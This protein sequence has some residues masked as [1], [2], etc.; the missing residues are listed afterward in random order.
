MLD[1]VNHPFGEQRHPHH[2]RH[3]R[4]PNHHSRTQVDEEPEA[5]ARPRDAT[6][7]ALELK[8]VPGRST[9]IGIIL[10]STVTA[11]L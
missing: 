8:C 6:D 11:C 9:A 2:D 4:G 3:D 5:G 7:R 1:A 10:W